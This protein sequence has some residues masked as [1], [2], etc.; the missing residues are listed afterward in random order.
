MKVGLLMRSGPRNWVEFSQ[1]AEQA[2]FDCVWF[3]EHLILPVDMSGAPGTPNEGH[4]PIPSDMPAWDP[5]VVMAYL[6]GQTK[7]IRFGTNVYNLG[8]RHP[9]ITAQ[10]LTTLDLVSQGRI[11]LGIGVSWLAQEWEAMQLPFQGRGARIDETIQ[12]IRRLFTEDTISHEGQFYRFQPVK[13]EPKPVQKPWPPFLIGGDAPAALRR[14]A[15][16]GDGWIPMRQSLE[17]L[18]ANLKQ[19][20]AMR[21]E[22]GRDGPFEVIVQAGASSDPDGLVKR[23]EDAEPP[24]RSPPPGCTQWTPPTAS[25]ATARRC[26][27]SS[28]L[29][30]RPHQALFASLAQALR[31]RAR[32]RCRR[33]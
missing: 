9:I 32:G 14:A 1:L 6:A 5:F 18:P 17:T 22:A 23:W 3:P 33:P 29:P 31:H 7:T 12:V 28:S 21:A 30:F 4:P 2:G 25:A 16:L 26:S 27:R 20:Q 8:L 10:A 15:T 24:A 13:F 11:D 19:I